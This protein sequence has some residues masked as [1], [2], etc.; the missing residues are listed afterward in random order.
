M[1][2]ISYSRVSPR[3][4]PIPGDGPQRAERHRVI[5]PGV[6]DQVAFQ[7]GN[8]LV[9]VGHQGQVGRDHELGTRVGE[10]VEQSPGCGWPRRSASSTGAGGGTGCWCWRR[11]RSIAPAGGRRRSAAATG[12]GPA[13]WPSGRRGPGGTGRPGAWRPACRRRSGPTSTCPGGCASWPGR[14][15]AERDRLVPHRSASQYQANMH[16]HPTTRSLRKGLIAR[17]KAAGS[18]G[19]SC[20]KTVLPL[21]S[22]TWMNMVLACRSTPQ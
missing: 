3:I 20:S 15:R 16:S 5:D 7:L 14:G 6:L 13:A 21:W 18:A 10:P 1:S 4:G 22:R 17:S 2:P 11:G 19:R 9:V 12:R 8:P